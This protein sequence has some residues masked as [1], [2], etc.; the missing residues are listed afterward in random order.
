VGLVAWVASEEL[1]VAAVRRSYRQAAVAQG[2]ALALRSFQ[3]AAVAGSIIRSIAVALLMV[4]AQ[5]LT[6]L[7]ER[8]V[9]TRWR[10]AEQARNSRSIVQAAICRAIVVAEVVWAIV[11]AGWVVAAAP[12][13]DWVIAG[14]A[15]V[16]AE[17]VEA[18]A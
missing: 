3:R 8:R 9:E 11:A 14:A 18:T 13:A 4:I 15:W 16:A 2:V 10:I 12:A 6:A 7:A 5:R 1:A 17:D